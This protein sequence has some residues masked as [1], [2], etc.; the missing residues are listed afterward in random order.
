GKTFEAERRINPEPSGACACCGLKI[1][2][3]Q[4][5]IHLVY[6][7]ARGG[8]ERDEQWLASNDQGNTFRLVLSHPWKATICPMS[9]ACLGSA[10]PRTVAAWENR[11][12][13]WFSTL[14]PET[15]KTGD[16]ISPT[17]SA[18]KYP[19]AVADATG[20]LLLVWVEGAGWQK[21]GS[22]AWQLF[23]RQNHEL[24]PP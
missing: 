9:S 12:R 18:Q 21:G 5:R 13:I 7:I 24:A 20:P 8:S 4:R 16:P 19:V 11:G 17:G 3:D 23:D 22:L 10:G 15:G 6:R 14:D 1:F 2:S